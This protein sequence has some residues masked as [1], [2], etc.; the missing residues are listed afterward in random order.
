M[1]Q[2]GLRTCG[3]QPADKSLINRRLKAHPVP[4]LPI[5]VTT[6]PVP[7]ARGEA[8]HP[9]FPRWVGFRVTL[10]RHFSR[11]LRGLRSENRLVLRSP[12]APAVIGLYLLA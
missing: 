10:G 12:A 6:K 5:K 3:T 2:D 1:A 4:V 8:V 9:G 7:Q 11:N